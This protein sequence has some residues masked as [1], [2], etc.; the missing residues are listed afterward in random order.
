MCQCDIVNLYLIFITYIVLYGSLT[1]SLSQVN[2]WCENKTNGNT[3]VG[4]T[5]EN[6]KNHAELVQFT[7]NWVY[8]QF[9]RRIEVDITSIC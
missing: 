8:V 2:K 9:F 7:D 5:G 6:S 1:S 3:K 4:I